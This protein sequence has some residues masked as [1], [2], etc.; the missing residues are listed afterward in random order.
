MNARNE[1][2]ESLLDLKTKDFDKKIIERLLVN[3]DDILQPSP[4]EYYWM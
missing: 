4:K 2:G 1:N 3:G